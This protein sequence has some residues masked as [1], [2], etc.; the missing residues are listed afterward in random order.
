MTMQPQGDLPKDPGVLRTVVRH[1]DQ[2]L[3]VYASVVGPG[4]VAV[5]DPVERG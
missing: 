1:A 2:N 3:G 5:G 4:P